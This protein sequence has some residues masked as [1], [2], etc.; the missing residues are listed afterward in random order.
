MEGSRGNGAISGPVPLR[1]DDVVSLDS[2]FDSLQILL[3]KLRKRRWKK[4]FISTGRGRRKLAE[5]YPQASSFLLILRLSVQLFAIGCR[6][7][8]ALRSYQGKR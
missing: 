1:I 6:I 8:T 7:M 5:A 3:W 4:R 2:S